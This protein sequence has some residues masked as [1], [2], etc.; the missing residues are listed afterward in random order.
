MIANSNL[1]TILSECGERQEGLA[2]SRDVL[3][4][5]RLAD[6]R[7][8]AHPMVGFNHA[9]ELALNGTTDFGHDLVSGGGYVGPGAGGR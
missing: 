5:L 3:E 9:T 1:V 4:Q 7:A 2:I 8:R 6:P